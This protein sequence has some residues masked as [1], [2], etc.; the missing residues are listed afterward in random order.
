MTNFFNRSCI[1]R[2]N[3][4]LYCT[5]TYELSNVYLIVKKLGTYISTVIEEL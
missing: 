4:S 5:T 1:V 3:V 2:M